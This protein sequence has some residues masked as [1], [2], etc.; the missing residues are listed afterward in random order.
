MY[1]IPYDEEYSTEPVPVG[2]DLSDSSL[3]TKYHI[4]E[5]DCVLGI[6]AYTQ[7]LDAVEQFL[8]FVLEES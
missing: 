2:I 5:D 8:A 3:V 6:S 4:Y 1:C 7:R